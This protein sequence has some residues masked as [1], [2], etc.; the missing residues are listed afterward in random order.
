VT[1]SVVSGGLLIPGL[2]LVNGLL[3]FFVHSV[4]VCL[5]VSSIFFLSFFFLFF[6]FFVFSRQ[7]FSV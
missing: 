7:G 3:R 2:L 1:D 5:S 6:C 4:C